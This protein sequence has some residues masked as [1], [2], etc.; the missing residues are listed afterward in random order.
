MFGMASPVKLHCT[1]GKLVGS[2]TFLVEL[3]GGVTIWKPILIRLI[4]NFKTF[5]GNIY[6]LY[7]IVFKSKTLLNKPCWSSFSQSEPNFQKFM[8]L[9]INVVNYRFNTKGALNSSGHHSC[10][11]TKTRW[12]PTRNI[13]CSLLASEV[14]WCG[15][16]TNKM[17][18]HKMM[19]SASRFTFVA[20]ATIPP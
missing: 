17:H 1:S 18:T 11:R 5:F 12:R 14:G 7:F 6:V 19:F 9:K 4:G 13:F 15:G 20:S 3:F 8:W 16:I 10:G 2:R